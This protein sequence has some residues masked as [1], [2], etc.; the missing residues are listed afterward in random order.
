M[1][2]TDRM[3]WITFQS[4]AKTSRSP[5]CMNHPTFLALSCL[6]LHK[7]Q[8][9][10][11][12]HECRFRDG[13][14]VDSFQAPPILLLWTSPQQLGLTIGCTVRLSI[15]RAICATHCSRR[16][17]MPVRMDALSIAA[18]VTSLITLCVEVSKYL[19]GVKDAPKNSKNLQVQ[20]SALEHVLHQLDRFL[21]GESL[22]G[23]CSRRH[24]FCVRL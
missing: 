4:T 5:P 17:R 20:V 1:L 19:T 22:K 16:R 11:P 21:C 3:Q 6:R 12:S 24:L 10:A 13:R 7:T 8:L 9:W 15:T 2:D 14:H 23:K 18:S